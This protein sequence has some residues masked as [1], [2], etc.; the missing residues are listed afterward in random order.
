MTVLPDS[1]GIEGVAITTNQNTAYEV[2][3]HAGGQREELENTTASDDGYELM[4]T[5]NLKPEGPAH[6]RTAIP[7]PI[8][9]SVS[10]VGEEE[11][12]GVYDNI[13]GDDQ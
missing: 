11:E 12:E 13:P 6:R 1:P 7:T 9:E 8:S 5:M 3:R 10:G 4:R 2:M